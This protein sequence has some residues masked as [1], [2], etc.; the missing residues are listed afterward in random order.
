MYNLTVIFIWFKIN[1][2]ETFYYEFDHMNYL[3]LFTIIMKTF[4]TIYF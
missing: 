2:M 4:N 1:F 3:I